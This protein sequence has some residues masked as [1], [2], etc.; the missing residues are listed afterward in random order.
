MT[1]KAIEAV[2][3][4]LGN[5]WTYWNYRKS[6]TYAQKLDLQ[7]SGDVFS[8]GGLYLDVAVAL[9]NVGPELVSS[10]GAETFP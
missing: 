2:A 6:R 4:L 3:V 5:V 7:V 8:R 1:D 10:Y 9:E